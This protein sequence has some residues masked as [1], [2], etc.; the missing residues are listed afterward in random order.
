MAQQAFLLKV[1]G[2]PHIP[3]ITEVNIRSDAGTNQ[4]LVFKVPVG[5]SNLPISEVKIDL[6]GRALESKVYQWFRVTFPQG[7]GWVRD[8]LV[9]IWG[10]GTK[11]GYPAI[12]QPVVAYALTRAATSFQ[13]AL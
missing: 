12:T 8:D 9:E 6:E 5:T 13:A 1:I 10:D 4:N 3:S 11:F 2:I 7:Q